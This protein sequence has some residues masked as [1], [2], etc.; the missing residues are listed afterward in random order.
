[1]H[2]IT[3]AV[4]EFSSSLQDAKMPGAIEVLNLI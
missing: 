1:L 4:L 2:V 3:L